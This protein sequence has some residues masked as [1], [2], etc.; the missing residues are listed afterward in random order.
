MLSSMRRALPALLAV[1]AFLAPATA[2]ASA[3]YRCL[4]MGETRSSC[5]CPEEAHR[6]DEAERA[7]TIKA[8]PCCDVEQPSF[9]AAHPRTEASSPRVPSAA[10]AVPPFKYQLLAA[11]LPAA[12]SP[13]AR[14]LAAPPR[15]S[16]PFILHCS[17]LL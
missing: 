6:A 13:S 7:A 11:S 17:L 4:A 2:L 1:L 5:C 9:R 16:P 8:I 15:G 12:V 3:Q 10:S 14:G